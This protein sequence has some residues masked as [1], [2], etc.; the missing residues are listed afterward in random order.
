[1]EENK[2]P[3][4]FLS[5]YV[6]T[7]GLIALGLALAMLFTGTINTIVIKFQDLQHVKGIGKLPPAP[8]EHPFTQTTVMFLGEFCCLF[9]YVVMTLISRFKKKGKEDLVE[10][11]SPI[12]ELS[13]KKSKKANPLFFIIPA[14]CDLLGTSLLNLGLIYTYASVYQM[15]RGMLVV[16]NALLATIFLKKKYYP[17]HWGSVLLILI[18]L[19]VVGYASVM[20]AGEGLHVARSPV[21][22]AILVVTAQIFFAIQFVVQ[23]KFLSQFEIVPLQCVGYEGF[24]GVMLTIMFLFVLYWVP[25]SDY[26]SVESVPYALGQI[27]VHP[28]L[29]IAIL[30]AVASIAFF[31]FFG[32][33]ITKRIGSTTR[34]VIDS[35]RTMF[36]WIFSLIIGWESFKWLQLVGFV[37]LVTGTFLFN[38]VIVIPYYNAWYLKKKAADEERKMIQK[39]IKDSFE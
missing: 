14:L 35:C 33:T 1:M 2:S 24:W 32:I 4:N 26:G 16:F 37:I 21:L 20:N 28:P 19:A 18:G 22:G 38:E 3:L 10:E 7:N 13:T 12:N 23:E 9:A 27:I 31:N 25:G 6:S 15:L 17:H 5:K 34:S 11:S 39:G 30:T 8:F 29:L 36:I